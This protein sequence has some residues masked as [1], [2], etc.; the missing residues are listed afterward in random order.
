MHKEMIITLT[1]MESYNAGAKSAHSAV[2]RMK[3]SV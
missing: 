3:I 2:G 1:M